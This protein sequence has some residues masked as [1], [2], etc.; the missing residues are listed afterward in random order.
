MK[1]YSL[2]IVV[3][4]L[5]AALG[6]GY[7]AADDGRRFAHSGDGRIQLYSGKNGRS[8]SGEYDLGA[9]NY[10]QKALDRIA[11][12]FGSPKGDP[13]A[14]IALRLIAF[15]DFIQDHFDP[16]ARIEIVSGWRSP[17]YNT[18]LRKDGR[19]A[20]TASLHQYGMAADIVIDGVSSERVWHFVRRLGFGGTGYYHGRTVHVDVGPARFWDESSS[21]VGTGLADDNKLIGLVTDYDQYRPGELVV[22]RFIRMT[23]FPIGVVPE[24]TLE[25]IGPSTESQKA[26]AG[27]PDFNVGIEGACPRFAAIADMMNIRYR[28]PSQLPPGEYTLCARFCESDWEAMPEKVATPPFKIVSSAFRFSPTTAPGSAAVWRQ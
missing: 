17:D 10:D 22:L 23:A 1:P 24:F 6:D 16:T 3:W 8:F 21:G 9:G 27:R 13:L 5:C 15:L 2:T 20:A 14:H 26:A 19:L 11:L 28:L 25:R 7:A 4:L 12:V 18:K